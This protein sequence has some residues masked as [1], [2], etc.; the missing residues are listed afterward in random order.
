MPEHPGHGPAL[1]DRTAQVLVVQA[2]ED[3]PQPLELGAVA[4]DVGR[5]VA[6]SPRINQTAW[7]ICQL[8]ANSCGSVSSSAAAAGVNDSSAVVSADL[9][10]EPMP[11]SARRASA[12]LATHRSEIDSR[13]TSMG[14]PRD[15]KSTRLNSSHLV[16]SYAVF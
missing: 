10:V 4:L 9:A 12:T 3:G 13:R 11:V 2:R 16:I 7:R 14:D 1:V 6:H 5:Q 8:T 15:R